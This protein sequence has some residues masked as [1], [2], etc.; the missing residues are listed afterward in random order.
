MTWYLKVLKSSFV[1]EG[2]ARRK[3]YWMFVLFNLI[4]SFALAFLGGLVAAMGLSIVFW[5]ST[6]YN[7]FILIP[8]IS[9]GVRRIHDTNHSGW[10]ILVPFFNLFLFCIEGDKGD[11]PFGP[12]PKQKGR[13]NAPFNGDRSNV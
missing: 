12:D 9:V 8:S 2:R 4:I 6:L 7:I 13:L 10:F 11:N 3:E 1:F 5:V